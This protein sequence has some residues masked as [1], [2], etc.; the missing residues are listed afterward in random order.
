MRVTCGEV[1]VM[2]VAENKCANKERLP[3]TLD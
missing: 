2:D 3:A 1:L